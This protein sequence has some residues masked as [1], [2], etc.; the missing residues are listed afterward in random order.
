MKKKILDDLNEIANSL[1]NPDIE[2]HS[3]EIRQ[4][5]RELETYFYLTSEENMNFGKE[6]DEEK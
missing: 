6:T 3:D 4:I 2:I 5:I 1:D